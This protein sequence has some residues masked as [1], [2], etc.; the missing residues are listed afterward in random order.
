MNEEDAT[1]KTSTSQGNEIGGM[2]QGEEEAGM[3]LGS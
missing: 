1:F 3:C 2:A